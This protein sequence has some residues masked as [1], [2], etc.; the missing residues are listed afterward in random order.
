MAPHD[1][2]HKNGVP[3][4][5]PALRR[6]FP[7]SRAQCGLFKEAAFEA[8][9]H[10]EVKKLVKLLRKRLDKIYND[11]SDDESSD[12]DKPQ[13]VV[14]QVQKQPMQSNLLDFGQ[15]PGT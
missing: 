12:D 11:D 8:A 1:D 5:P 15:N 14:N 13:P 10:H 9:A 6:A 4:V 2:V 3:C 7:D